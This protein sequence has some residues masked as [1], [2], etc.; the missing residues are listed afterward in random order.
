MGNRPNLV[1][2][3]KGFKPGPAGWRVTRERLEQIDAKGNLAW[4]RTG[5]VRRKLRPADIEKGQPVGSLWADIRPI[6][7]QAQER[8]GYPTQKPLALLDRIIKA[9]TNE[10][11]LV[12]DPFC[13]CGST[14]E[15]ART[16]GRR[17]CGIDISAF[18]VDIV[19]DVRLQDPT[20]PTLGIPADLNGAHKLAA[21]KPFAFESWA[22]SRLPGF[23]PNVRQRGDGGIDGRATLATDPDDAETRLALAQVK[24]GKF[25]VSYLRDFQHVMSDTQAALGYFLTLVPPPPEARRQRQDGGADS[26]RWPAVRSAATLVDG[27]VLRRPL[28]DAASDDGPVYRAGA[29]AARSVQGRKSP[30][31][32]DNRQPPVRPTV[33]LKRCTYQPSK[34]ELEEPVTVPPGTTPEDLARAIVRPVNVV[35]ED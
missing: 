21:E 33:R 1:Y 13:G 10:G 25:S 16:L 24:G 29:G 22:V 12:L 14:V 9:S 28:A 3:Y 34:A 18:A 31:S 6:N 8:L 5:G 4:T 27:G 2:E 20:V 23:A 11:D 17:W 15:A 26:R 30:M 7:S 32:D 19:K 35:Y